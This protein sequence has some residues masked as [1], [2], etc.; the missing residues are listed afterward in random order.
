MPL[1]TS[2]RRGVADLIPVT[3]RH[4][5][6][7]TDVA[8]PSSLPLAEILP[9]VAARLGALDEESAVYGLMLVTEDGKP[10]SDSRP[11]DEQGV[12]AGALLT[13][14]VRST[15]AE[16]RYDDLVEAV[17]TAVETKQVAWSREDSLSMSV[18]STCLLF[19][20]A[21]LLLLRQGPG[22]IVTPVCALVCGCLLV[23]AAF[24][25]S[26][27]RGEGAWPLVMT[28][29]ALCAVAAHT[30]FDGP[31][32]GMRMIAAGGALAAVVLACLP[33]SEPGP[34]R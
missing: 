24:V 26:R 29:G 6:I 31:P 11:V 22:Q 19:L 27:L 12:R 13:L 30:A 20:V 23:L 21:G 17:A 10:L 3:I 9:A 2:T 25:I 16:A 1:T 14:E 18:A 5:N 8:L 15:Q 4:R 32:T 7:P 28:A 34:R 33:P